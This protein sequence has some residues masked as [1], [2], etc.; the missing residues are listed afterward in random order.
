MKNLYKIYTEDGSIYYV[1]ASSI[2]EAIDNLL[3][4]IRENY[5]YGGKKTILSIDTIAM[6][7]LNLTNN[8][9]SDIFEPIT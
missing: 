2:N 3:F 1:T 5:V 7:N 8:T 6:C 4:Y 9:S